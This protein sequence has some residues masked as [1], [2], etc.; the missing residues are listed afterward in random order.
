MVF[1]SAHRHYDLLACSELHSFCMAFFLSSVSKESPSI[2]SETSSHR[3]VTKEWNQTG[4]IQQLLTQ[5]SS[6]FIFLSGTLF[7]AA[8]PCSAGKGKF[9]VHTEFNEKWHSTF[10]FLID[11]M[12][13]CRDDSTHFV[14][15][16]FDVAFSMSQCHDV[17]MTQHISISGCRDVDVDVDVCPR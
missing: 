12:S 11:A 5:V 1:Y 15:N 3:K 16:V 9:F 6:L 2:P 4:G 8:L 13:R 14:F 17:T 7:W 10:W